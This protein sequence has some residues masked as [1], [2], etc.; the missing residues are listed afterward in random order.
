MLLEPYGSVLH[1]NVSAVLDNHALR[2]LGYGTGLSP[3]HALAGQAVKGHGGELLD[4]LVAQVLSGHI[5]RSAC[6]LEC[7]LVSVKDV[8]KRQPF[9]LPPERIKN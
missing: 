9:T 8:Y 2:G 7:L 1:T 3:G 5:R 6:I 4:H